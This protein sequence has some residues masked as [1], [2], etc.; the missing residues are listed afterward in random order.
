MPLKRENSAYR[1]IE[2]AEALEATWMALQ[3]NLRRL[4]PLKGKDRVIDPDVR[5]E[6]A[7]TLA[8]AVLEQ[9]ALGDIHLA[10]GP[11]TSPHCAGYR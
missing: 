5:S 2:D 9:L 8:R 4:P 11:G 7:R 3:L 10:K 1:L 6:A